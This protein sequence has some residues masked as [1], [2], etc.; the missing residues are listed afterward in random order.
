MSGLQ[1]GHTE[2]SQRA[3]PAEVRAAGRAHSGHTECSQRASTAEVRAAGAGRTDADS[4]SQLKAL[5][6]RPPI[7]LWTWRLSLR[8][9]LSS[10]PRLRVSPTHRP[11]TTVLFSA[12]GHPSYQPCD[13]TP[14]PSAVGHMDLSSASYSVPIA[15]PS[16]NRTEV[17]SPVLPG[18]AGTC[19]DRAGERRWPARRGGLSGPRGALRGDPAAEGAEQAGGRQAGEGGGA[20]T[21]HGSRTLAAGGFKQTMETR[22]KPEQLDREQEPLSEAKRSQ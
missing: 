5:T 6:A 13:A 10:V 1:G 18:V 7:L 11:V 3:S 4:V 2:G 16:A 19:A 8:T 20:G 12:L 17:S 21:D 14:S 22:F 9:C 15:V